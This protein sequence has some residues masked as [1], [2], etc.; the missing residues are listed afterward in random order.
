MGCSAFHEGA[1]VNGFV[2]KTGF[3]FDAYACNSLNHMYAQLGKGEYVKKL[4]EEMPQR[5]FIGM[6][7]F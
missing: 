5:E 3:E 4:F 2:V 1:K 7:Q 6:P